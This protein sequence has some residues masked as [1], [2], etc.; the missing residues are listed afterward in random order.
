MNSVCADAATS[1]ESAVIN[2]TTLSNVACGVPQNIVVTPISVSSAKVSWTPVAGADYYRIVLTKQG[3]V[4]LNPLTY[5][6]ASDNFTFTSLIA[7]TEYTVKVASFCNNTLSAFSTITNII[8]PNVSCGTPATFTASNTNINVPNSFVF[9]WAAVPGANSYKLEYKESTASVY[10][11]ALTTFSTTATFSQFKFGKTYD[12]RVSAICAGVLGTPTATQTITTPPLP[13]CPSPTTS[14]VS[15]VTYYS[16]DLTWAAIAGTTYRVSYSK[17]GTTSNVLYYAS[18]SPFK[19]SNLTPNTTYNYTLYAFCNNT[20]ATTGTSGT[21]TTSAAP[22]CDP[23][24]NVSVSNVTA[25]SATLSWTPVVGATSYRI[26]RVTN[27]VS[28]FIGSSP[29]PAYNLTGLTSSS[30]TSYTVSCNCNNIIGQPSASVSVTTLAATNCDAPSNINTTFVDIQKATISWTAV[31]GITNYRLRYVIAGASNF[32]QVTTNKTTFT[33]SGLQPNT[34]YV[35]A[36]ASVCNTNTSNIGAFSTDKTFKTLVPTACQVPTGLTVTNIGPL[37]AKISWDSVG[38]VNYWRLQV[39]P[40]SGSG[41]IS[42]SYKSNIVIKGL[43]PNTTYKVSLSANCPVNS[44]SDLVTTTFTTPQGVACPDANEPNESIATAAALPLGVAKTGAISGKTD[45]DFFAFSNSAAQPNIKVS[46]T[47]LPEDYDLQLYNAAGVIVAS[48][49]KF[50]LE[51]ETLKLN[52][53]PVGTYY[54][55]IVVLG[56]LFNPFA[57]YTIK[58]ETSATPYGFGAEGSESLIKNPKTQNANAAISYNVFPNPSNGNVKV[59]FDTKTKGKMQVSFS[60]LNGRII[61]SENI[62]VSEANNAF[63]FDISDFTNGIYILNV[64]NGV[65]SK[66]TRVLKF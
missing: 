17:A 19:F 11:T 49:F 2:F 42:T 61:K 44:F 6:T 12:C 55:K 24:A 65:E 51:D 54:A 62:E 1:A 57:C 26:S 36:V 39:S 40:I 53:A 58:A 16:A 52:N 33:L 14:S 59:N 27:G 50:S 22:S 63:Q 30:T 5:S 25:F 47:N 7:N 66:I 28:S 34:N 21:F 38:S 20:V 48:S 15:N 8:T 41:F 31:A 56:N 43:Q 9:N 45:L 18:T 10:I 13:P 4:L 23:P 3:D 46:L 29:S 60:D 37:S 64:N 32:I 35:Y